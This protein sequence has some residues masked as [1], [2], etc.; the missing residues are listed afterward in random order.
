MGS[1]LAGYFVTTG[2][3]PSYPFKDSELVLRPR[4]H[5]KNRCPG[6]H[7]EEGRRVT[8]IFEPVGRQCE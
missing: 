3:V 6:S 7:W 4:G 8:Q 5:A 1:K 2:C